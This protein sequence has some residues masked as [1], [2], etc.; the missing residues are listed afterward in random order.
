MIIDES[1]HLA[2][3]G[4]LRRSG[5]YPWGS[6]GNEDQSSTNKS[7]LGW[8]ADMKKQ[9]LSEKEIA[10]G[11]SDGDEKVSIA[12]LRAEITVARNEQRQ[13]NI[14]MAQRLKDK[15]NSHVAIGKRMGVN[16]SV[17]RSWLAPGAAAK[18]DAITQTSDMLK[19][20]V[21][22]KKFVDI[23][24]GVASQLG[25]ADTRLN[26]A[27]H[28]LRAEGYA[29][30]LV[31]I[32]QATND[33]ETTFKVL[34][35]PGT[36]YGD[37]RK[38]Y[39]DIKQITGRTLDGGHTFSKIHPAM[40]IDPKRVQV[41]YN[42]DGGGKADGIIYVRPGVKDVSIGGSS[43]AQV[44]VQVGDGHYLK[45]VAM[46]K[47]D[48][49]KGVDLAFN[50]NKSNTGSKLN[51]MKEL[52]S[53]PDMPFGAMIKRQVLANE[54]S[55]DPAKP[56]HVTSVMNIVNEEGDWGRW[57]KH[58]S[59]QFLSK[60]H[61]SLAKKQLGITAE[62]RRKEYDEI[63]ALNNPTI[64]KKLLNEFAEG[65]DASA[66]NLKAA[67]L[68]EDARY[69]VIL[70]VSSMSPNEVYA[71]NFENGTRV[72][73]VRYPHG[74]TFEL[75]ELTV[76]NRQ[77]EA[78]RL[79]GDAID[80]VG[81][82]HSVAEQMSG[83]DFDGDFVVVIPNNNK[84]VK[85]SLPL[86]G[87]K[88]FDPM[89]YKY[90]DDMPHKKMS[91]K[92]KQT[93]MGKVSNLITD[94]TIRNAPTEK[95][96]RAIRH[97]M[98]VIDAE[99]HDLNYRL[100]AQDNG[101]RQLQEEYQNP[102]RE[103]GH[104]GSSTL[105][106]RARSS[107]DVPDRK[108]RL[109]K[110]GGP[111]DRVTGEVRYS[112]TNKKYLDKNG[113]EVL[114]TVGSTRLAETNDAHTLSSGTPIEK[115]Y[116]DH[117]NELKAMANKAR[118]EALHTPN[119]VYSPSANKTYADEVASLNTKLAIAVQNR[120][121]ERQAQVIAKS[122][123]DAKLYNNPG[124]DTSQKKK[125]RQ[126]AIT[127]ARNRVGASKKERQIEITPEEWNAIQAGAISN[128]KLEQ[129]LTNTDIDKLRELA[130]PHHKVLMSS[131]KVARAQG[132]LALGYTRAEIA[133][134]LGVGVTTLNTALDGEGD[135]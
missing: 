91:N 83:A 48:L 106:S 129:I 14:L 84:K 38:N 86:E 112:P 89:S 119:L 43:Y 134:Q 113:K 23:G 92:A 104:P 13:S 54:G 56:E 55:K 73:L 49:P 58:L 117:S 42:E 46:Y 41:I 68:A 28:V 15:G 65:A 51:A 22:E 135:E 87:L 88:G 45:G 85:T 20:Q 90:P 110:D 95:I 9:G 99:K 4:V 102:F 71:P 100:S 27:V 1:E 111:V 116:A 37:I 103:S 63:M 93:E 109:A 52:G 6:G 96:V 2:H 30:H 133:R 72:V 124:L 47:D 25:L 29:V 60:Q 3:Y 16:E 70:P 121:L 118:L 98:V 122:V 35:P 53:D 64:R 59:S 81:I 97:S 39:A 69:H 66:V 76:N 57:S 75:P 105:I 40:S 125:I 7:F 114:K 12:Q 62:N 18:T 17:V 82:H 107:I 123:I 50:T 126:Q 132:M 77:P 36:T 11:L 108:K 24:S 128:H 5:R 127:V 80:A 33:K 78:R 130:T 8:V 31:K 44:R 26:A 32:P 34:A 10:Q 94:M 19:R 131:N 21:E 61:P 67:G 101:I 115:I 79:L 74:G 120:P